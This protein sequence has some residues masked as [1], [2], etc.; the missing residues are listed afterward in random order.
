MGLH[1]TLS[2][3]D[4]F[5]RAGA[6]VAPRLRSRA[7]CHSRSS[8]ADGTAAPRFHRHR[9]AKNVVVGVPDIAPRLEVDD[10]VARGDLVRARAFGIEETF[11]G[12]RDARKRGARVLGRVG[13]LKNLF[14][15][16]FSLFPRA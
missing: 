2:A 6:A 16:A 3:T 4:A 5:A 10:E 14:L 12:K 9:T 8:S 15:H 11:V 1:A 7:R 13:K